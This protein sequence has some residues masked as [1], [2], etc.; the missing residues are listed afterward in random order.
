METL[1]TLDQIR[2]MKPNEQDEY[3]DKLSVQEIENLLSDCSGHEIT[4]SYS[5]SYIVTCLMELRKKI[6]NISYAFTEA[7]IQA[8]VKINKELITAIHKSIEKLNKIITLFDSDTDGGLCGIHLYIEPVMSD[9][10]LDN[11]SRDKQKGIYSI[12]DQNMPK[13]NIYGWDFG[14]HEIIAN[15]DVFEL[16]PVALNSIKY[17][18]N[19]KADLNVCR[20]FS[21]L[22]RNNYLSIVDMQKI[23]EFTVEMEVEYIL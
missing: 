3:I 22:V 11:I 7:N 19:A 6:I 17:F 15:E 13:I 8:L 12:L 16:N 21:D 14:P 2:R 9:I 10:S 18:E 4:E 23:I 20:A 5:S 1:Y